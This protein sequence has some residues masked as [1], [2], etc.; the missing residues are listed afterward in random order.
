M[1]AEQGK[2]KGKGNGK[3]AEAWRLDVEM[4]NADALMQEF[5][6]GKGKGKTNGKE[7]GELPDNETSVDSDS[8]TLSNSSIRRMRIQPN[9]RPLSDD[10]LDR[11]VCRKL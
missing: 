10:Q 2:G 4:Q 1:D 7:H 6:K 5:E 9:A 8:S 11:R 3:M